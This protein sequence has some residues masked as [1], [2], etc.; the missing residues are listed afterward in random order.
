VIRDKWVSS[1]LIFGF[2]KSVLGKSISKKGILSK[3]FYR[4]NFFAGRIGNPFPLAAYLISQWIKEW[5]ILKGSLFILIIMSYSIIVANFKIP[6]KPNLREQDKVYDFILPISSQEPK[7]RAKNESGYSVVTFYQIVIGI[8]CIYRWGNI[9][10][11][12][13][14]WDMRG[15]GQAKKTT[16]F[17]ILIG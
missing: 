5:S 8:I 3:V 14:N 16:E 9:T 1:L 15:I 2:T 10:F 7:A 12:G 13:A 11:L 17:L 4:R 6:E